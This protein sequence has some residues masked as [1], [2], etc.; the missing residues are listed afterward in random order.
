MALAIANLTVCVEK[1]NEAKPFADML[2]G[3]YQSNFTTKA[4]EAQ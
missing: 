3:G 4:A 1:F 2:G